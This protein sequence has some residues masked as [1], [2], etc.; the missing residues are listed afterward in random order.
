MP[1]SLHILCLACRHFISSCRASPYL[2]TTHAHILSAL[3]CI[4]YRCAGPGA[5]F[6]TI[7]SFVHRGTYSCTPLGTHSCKHDH[8]HPRQRLS[9]ELDEASGTTEEFEDPE[10]SQANLVVWVQNRSAKCCKDCGLSFT[11][12][13]RALLHLYLSVTAHA[14]PLVQTP[15]AI[16]LR[17]CVPS[18]ISVFHVIWCPGVCPNTWQPDL[19]PT[20]PSGWDAPIHHPHSTRF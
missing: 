14:S 4:P 19:S 6:H 11:G 3:P 8:T 18:S 7:A 15:L 12:K 10:A 13:L 2:Y 16:S 1:Q 5:I 17:P 20:Q 9:A